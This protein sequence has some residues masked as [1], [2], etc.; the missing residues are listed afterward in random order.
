MDG[1]S[2][3]PPPPPPPKA[4]SSSQPE[5]PNQFNNRGGRG[6]R[7]GRGNRGSLRGRGGA[8]QRGGGNFQHQNT[9]SN[10][11]GQNTGNYQP[12]YGNQQQ[13]YQTPQHYQAPPGSYVNP[14]FG[15]MQAQTYSQ[16]QLPQYGQSNVHVAG[17]I[18]Q[19]SYEN[20]NQSNSPFGGKRTRD[21]AFGNSNRGHP[22]KKPSSTPKAQ[23]APAVP[24][25]G[26]PILPQ[27]PPAPLSS[28][29]G[30]KQR[31]STGLGLIPQDYGSPENSDQ[32]EDEDEEEVDEEAALSALQNGPLSFEFNGELSTL[33]SAAD[34]AEWI[35][36]R[37]KRWPSKRR[38]E[39]KE[40]E[41]QSRMEERRRIEQETRAAIAS[42]SGGEYQPVERRDD[43]TQRQMRKP[44]TDR[45]ARHDEGPTLEDTQKELVLQMQ[46]V[47]ELQ[48]LLAE[49]GQEQQ[50]AATETA[51]QDVD[52]TEQHEQAASMD[53]MEID[54]S[55]ETSN[56]GNPAD[57]QHLSDSD[58]DAPPEETSSKLSQP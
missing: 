49:K 29:G 45:Q 26:A 57:D 39:E 3:P 17:Q 9:N 25:F 15:G 21:Q 20:F 48:K 42:A 1:F 6:G 24:S 50:L 54:Q 38:V 55:L 4:A 11:Y 33:S 16:P 40:L 52:T 12:S 2:F 58:S 47:E 44:A 56:Q 18:N 28:G 5:N 43:R 23:V 36:E 35:E 10:G 32:D 13:H 19:P 53:N 34:I 30:I 22:M 8:P 41:I 14:A 46:K 7:G 37:K 51:G 31:P 27:K